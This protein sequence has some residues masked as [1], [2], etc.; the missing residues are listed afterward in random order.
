VD[1]TTASTTTT[2]A[3]NDADRIAGAAVR[4]RVLMAEDPEQPYATV[5]SIDRWKVEGTPFG[6]EIPAS[7]RQ[8]IEDALAPRSVEWITPDDAKGNPLDSATPG[9]SQPTPTVEVGTPTITGNTAT[10]DTAITC[11]NLCGYWGRATL[12]K[13][14]AGNWAVTG[15]DGPQAIS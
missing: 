11:G 9:T 14:V 13:G 6:E 4:W 2:I 15:T 8:A 3:V 10:V 1:T 5:R 7:T 12:E